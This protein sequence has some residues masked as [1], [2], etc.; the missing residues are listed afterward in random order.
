[1]QALQEEI[2]LDGR[3]LPLQHTPVARDYALGMIFAE[4]TKHNA[5]MILGYIGVRK[6]AAR[7][8]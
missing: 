3:T 7:R 1:M 5:E 4:F 6:Y 2:I 8:T